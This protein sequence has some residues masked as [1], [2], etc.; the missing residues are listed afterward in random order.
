MGREKPNSL[1]FEVLS[2]PSMTIDQDVAEGRSLF[3]N[4]TEELIRPEVTALTT[5]VP[6]TTKDPHGD[7][8]VWIDCSR[9]ELN[10]LLGTETVPPAVTE[11]GGVGPPL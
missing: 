2:C 10:V 8:C 1:E 9:L 7:A 5:L 11:Y 4:I 3:V 6:S